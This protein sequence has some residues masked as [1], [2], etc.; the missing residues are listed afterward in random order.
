M[1]TDPRDPRDAERR[2][3]AAA[4][5][6]A[7]FAEARAEALGNVQRVRARVVR[8]VGAVRRDL[9][10]IAEAR[11]LASHAAW[12]VGEVARV[13]RGATKLDYVDWSSGEAVPKS[14][15][16]DPAR[17]AREQLDDVFREAKRLRDG[18]PVAEA[19]LAR[20]ERAA[21]ALDAAI[22]ALGAA[23]DAAALEAAWDA[24]HAVLRRE[25]PEDARALKKPAAPGTKRKPDAPRP[26]YRAFGATGGRVLVGRGAEHNDELTFQV[27]KPWHLWLHARGVPGAHVI[28][29]L[30]RDQSC[31][32]E[33]LVDA[34]HLAA[35][36]S[37]AR[38]EPVVEVT[39]VPRKYV[40][41]PRRSLPGAVS[42]DRE[43]VLVLRVE[44][45]RK[46]RLL[47]AEE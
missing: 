7:A 43:K 24:L 35:H 15:P 6:A 36:F 11:A 44:E 16:L 31:P 1:P 37:D 2:E 13:P 27:S 12:I 14:I 47:A 4:S 41:K 22:G 32:G 23:A 45:A 5:A 8:R 42:F 19:R 3:A 39:Y 28:V 17:S 40:R 46:A 21:L 29:P 30:G 26:P 10:K 33:L 9:A 18:E 25:S 20:T 34:A 38:D